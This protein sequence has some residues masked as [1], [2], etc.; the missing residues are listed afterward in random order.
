[1][2]FEVTIPKHV[3]LPTTPFAK[4]LM[5]LVRLTTHW[6]KKKVNQLPASTKSCCCCCCHVNS[7][8]QV[9][10]HG[11]GSSHSGV[12]EYPNPG[13]KHD[14]NKSGTFI[15]H[16]VADATNACARKM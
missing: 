3:V 8:N 7:H 6:Q 15:Y 16:I 9:R 2:R 5:V 14:Q 10:D 1:M 12:K 13:N 4:K 11:T